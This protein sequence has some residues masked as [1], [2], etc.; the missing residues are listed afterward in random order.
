MDIKEIIESIDKK[1]I[2]GLITAL[3]EKTAKKIKEG[4]YGT[5]IFKAKIENG[6]ITIPDVEKEALGLSDGDVLQVFVRK[7]KK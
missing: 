1:D 5:G 2:P 6:K 3:E 4:F 7:F